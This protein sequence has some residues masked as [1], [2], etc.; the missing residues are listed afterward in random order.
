[1]RRHVLGAAAALFLAMFPVAS[2][3]AAPTITHFAMPQ[4]GSQPISVSLGVDGNVWFTEATYHG[5]GKVTPT[6]AVT[7]YSGLTEQPTG[8]ATPETYWPK[9]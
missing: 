4:V 7:E 5:V 3:Q 9:L 8:L 6:G 2:A 1:M